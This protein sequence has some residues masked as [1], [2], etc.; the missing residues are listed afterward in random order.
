MLGAAVGEAAAGR[1]L[2]RRALLWGGLAGTVPDLDVFVALLLGL[3]K[4]AG[5]RFHP[6][7][8]HAFAFAFVAAPVFGWLTARFYRSRSRSPGAARPH[9]GDARPW[10]ALYFWSLWARPL[11]DLFTNYGTQ[12]FWPFSRYPAALSSV[13]IIDLAYTTPFL[14]A[15][16]AAC[17]LRF[18]RTDGYPTTADAP[19]VFTFRFVA[20]GRGGA[21]FHQERPAFALGPAARALW[22]RTAGEVP[23][24][25]R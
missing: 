4:P 11:L 22:R 7:P 24:W 9:L 6:G 1:K 16:V 25:V 17:D 2:G 5:L 3:S 23:T 8:T 13:P 10:I 21:T 15:G 20:A 14:V 12:L 18:G 19:C